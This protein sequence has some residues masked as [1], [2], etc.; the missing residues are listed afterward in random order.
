M[1]DW[2]RL[3]GGGF[4][5][6]LWGF[7]FVFV[8]A[9]SAVV[10][11]GIKTLYAEQERAHVALQAAMA[12]ASRE[13]R[14]VLR[15]HLERANLA[16]NLVIANW[17]MDWG[18]PADR[19]HSVELLRQSSRLFQET[20]PEIVQIAIVRP[21][22]FSYPEDH[23]PNANFTA[24]VYMGDREHFKAVASG[25]ARVHFGN[26]IV[27]RLSGLQ[28]LQYAVA[29]RDGQGA[30]QMVVVVSIRAGVIPQV[31]LA[32]AGGDVGLAVLAWPNGKLVDSTV[33]GSNEVN[34]G[35]PEPLDSYSD[36]FKGWFISRKSPLDGV[37]R[38]VHVSYIGSQGLFLAMGVDQK[39]IQEQRYKLNLSVFI[40]FTDYILRVLFLFSI[41]FVVFYLWFLYFGEKKLYRDLINSGELFMKYYD[42]NQ[43]FVFFNV[44]NLK[45]LYSN[46]YFS[47]LLK[48]STK[49]FEDS[50]DYVR[51]QDILRKNNPEIF[52]RLDQ[53]AVGSQ[54]RDVLINIEADGRTRTIK[55]DITKLNIENKNGDGS[56]GL[57]G[58][59]GYGRDYTAIQEDGAELS[60]LRLDLANVVRTGPG[61][62]YR[63]YLSDNDIF[64]IEFPSGLGPLQPIFT[65]LKLEQ[66]DPLGAIKIGG[67]TAWTQ[68]I[69][70]LRANGQ[71]SAR[72]PLV[73][74]NGQVIWI[75][76]K[77][78]TIERSGNDLT[79]AGYYDDVTKLIDTELALEQA[80]QMARLGAITG[81]LSH[82]LNQPLAAI[83]MAAENGQMILEDGA[84]GMAEATE[85][86]SR[87]A[88][89]AQRAATIV[90][91]MRRFASLEGVAVAPT[92]LKSVIDSAILIM[93]A[94]IGAANL[95]VTVAVDVAVMP[96]SATYGLLEQVL[97]NLIA[98]AVD[99]HSAVPRSAE[100]P[101][102]IAIRAEVLANDFVGLT[103]ADNAGGFPPEIASRMFDPF[104]TTKG[105]AGGT[106][107]G[108]SVSFG[109][110][111]SW[112][113]SMGARNANGGA[114]FDMTLPVWKA[115]HPQRVKQR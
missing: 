77:C 75:Q 14:K 65:R 106:G 81:G 95:D 78:V 47:D 6:G 46:K 67:P 55:F 74:A 59:L 91:D 85:K 22:G 45:I 11:V 8:T 20:F 104:F 56:D 24:P 90:R 13:A 28:T 44:L 76:D 29:A 41:C 64:T 34:A 2:G 108:L 114:I 50:S 12:E 42:F 54:I 15:A 25:G 70:D 115:P 10:A 60:R 33:R 84:A 101:G 4:R 112:G 98:N 32:A 109:I 19:P 5:R 89:F 31:M 53:M 18:D 43:D 83:S 57:V 105:P 40:R 110:L 100:K 113:G 94:K 87:I 3:R 82:E 86:F 7:I 88:G 23:S 9:L 80:A 38:Y 96:V 52:D 35:F 51:F 92:P 61:A 37:E 21:D 66:S 39:I 26:R 79:V 73:D 27:G 99:A 71:A 16:A 49:N 1:L 102:W 103:V 36:Q 63:G 72:F 58:Y 69:K 93:A 68:F 97:V 48:I 30:L 107:L 62:P 17:R 111:K